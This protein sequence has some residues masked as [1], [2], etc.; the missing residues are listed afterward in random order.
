MHDGACSFLG[1]AEKDGE[2]FALLIRG[3]FLLDSSFALADLG[4]YCCHH[5]AEGA[6]AP[7]VFVT[8]WD[9]AGS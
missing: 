4:F 9:D 5:L 7:M 3:Q 6:I 8:D 2:L 1:D